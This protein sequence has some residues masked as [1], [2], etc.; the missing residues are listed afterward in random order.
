MRSTYLGEILRSE[1][2][3]GFADIWL[4]GLAHVKQ[5]F[6]TWQSCWKE[7]PFHEIQGKIQV[8]D[9][10][11]YNVSFKTKASLITRSSLMNYVLYPFQPKERSKLGSKAVTLDKLIAQEN[12]FFCIYLFLTKCD[13]WLCV[14][15]M[16]PQCAQI[17]GQTI[18]W[19]FL[20]VFLGMIYI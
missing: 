10:Y 2:K 12:L 1:D 20:W 17:F 16:G 13:N 9:N 15:L 19:V 6:W 14:N 11:Y 5:P 7:I 3:F 8:N 18:F 4:C